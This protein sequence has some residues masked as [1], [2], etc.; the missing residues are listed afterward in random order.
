MQEHESVTPY[1][2]GLVS[3]EKKVSSTGQVFTDEDRIRTMLRGL[4]TQYA[5]TRDL[6]REFY[7]RQ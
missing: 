4:L 7:K 6:L 1:V 5:M 2:D 3:L